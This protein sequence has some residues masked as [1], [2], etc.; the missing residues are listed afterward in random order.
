MLD[1]YV[2]ILASNKIKRTQGIIRE[3]Y[4]N[5]ESLFLLSTGFC[6]NEPTLLSFTVS[7]YIR[8]DLDGIADIGDSTNHYSRPDSAFWKDVYKKL[9][10]IFVL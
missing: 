1:C 9:M 3:S 7:C 2:S 10:I 4:H 8:C 5:F 6:Y